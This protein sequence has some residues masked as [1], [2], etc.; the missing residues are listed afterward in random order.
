MASDFNYS[1]AS[2]L[3]KSENE[4]GFFFAVNV[5]VSTVFISLVKSIISA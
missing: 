3:I 5:L 4:L 1:V 2:S